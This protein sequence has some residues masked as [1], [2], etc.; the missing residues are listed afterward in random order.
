[1]ELYL[2]SSIHLHGVHRYNFVFTFMHN[3]IKTS[4]VFNKFH[5]LPPPLPFR[6]CVGITLNKHNTPYRQQSSGMGLG[7]L[8]PADEGTYILTNVRTC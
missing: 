4:A 3:T 6:C 2:D 7:L 1:M 8:D 5:Q